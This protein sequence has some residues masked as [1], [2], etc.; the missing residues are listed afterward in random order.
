MCSQIAYKLRIE[1]S[2]V[3]VKATTQEQLG[4]IGKKEGIA[5]FATVLLVSHN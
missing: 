1:K 5:A 2:M 3:N 4:A